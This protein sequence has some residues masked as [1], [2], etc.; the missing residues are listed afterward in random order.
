MTEGV[1]SIHGGSSEESS[2]STVRTWIRAHR[3]ELLLGLLVLVIVGPVVQKDAAQQASRYVLTAAVVEEHTFALDEYV[4]VLGI[5]RAVFEGHT[6]SDKAP[7][8]PLLAVPFYA[9]YRWVGGEP[10][11]VLRVEGSLGLWWLT[12]WFAALPAAGLAILMYRAARRIAPEGALPAA[13][14]MALA[15]MLLPFSTLLFGHV[16]A[17]L[18]AL[19]AFMLVSKEL[20]AWRVALAGALVGLAVTVEYTMAILALVLGVYI[21]WRVRNRIGWYLLGGVPFAAA[22][23]VYNW[24]VFGNPTVFSYQLSAFSEVAD[25]PR[26]I[27]S[28]FSGFDP[29]RLVEVFLAPRGFLVATPLVILGLG[30]LIFMIRRRDTRIDGVFTSVLF[31]A[32]LALPVMWANPWGG[33]SPGARYMLPALPFLAVPLAM[34]WRR[35]PLVSLLAA[36]LGLL[37][38]GSATFTNPLLPREIGYGLTTWMGMVGRGEWVTTLFTMWLGDWGWLIHLSLV[39]VV[40]VGLWFVARTRSLDEIPGMQLRRLT[41]Q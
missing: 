22:L 23:A 20:S 17:A 8:Q 2:R 21:L 3:A 25:A 14:G 39:A 5:D 6:Y 32:F 28:I 38:M 37:T 35:I 24:A 36:G 7:G 30:G 31:L 12:F 1:E 29:A 34:V 40:A 26:R 13:L 15:T 41:F 10:G 4:D 19:A 11:T 9:L 27:G 16:L 33:D 18:L